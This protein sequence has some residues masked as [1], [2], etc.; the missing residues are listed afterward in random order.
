MTDPVRSFPPGPHSVVPGT[1]V[2]KFRRDVLGFLA[3]L[4]REYGDA[5][6][7]TAGLRRFYVFSHPDAVRDILVTHEDCF[8]K[9]PALRETKDMLG[10]GLLISEGDFHK[11]QRRLA[12]PAFHP[13]R[14]AGYADLMTRFARRLSDRWTD[15]QTIDLHQQMMQL[16]LAVVAKTLFDADVESDVAA[17]GQAMDTSVRMFTR[18]MIPF[19]RLLNLLPLPSNFRF[20][21]ARRL[22]WNK[23]AEFIKQRRDSGIDKG[24]LLSMLLRATDT[25]GD[26][27]GMSDV[28]LRDEC[29]TLFT[30]GHET[31]ANALTFTW[32]LLARH[33][34]IE[35]RMVDEIQTVLGD[36]PPTADDVP[37]LAY[38][39]AVIAESMRLY[40]P[41]WGIGR[42]VS[43]EVEIGGYRLPPK[44]VILVCQWVTH[45]DERFWPEALKFEPQRWLGKSDRPRYAY[46]PFGGGSRACIGEAFAWME[47][48]VLLTTLVQRWRLEL[49]DPAPIDLHPTIT[50]RP[51]NGVAAKLKRR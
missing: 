50:L 35:Q 51:R 21:S 16:T 4:A 7:F 40:P 43:R 14:V 29:I 6:S 39:R 25:E 30:A 48:I 41:A 33:P 9:G 34:E 3:G 36:R 11:R 13:Q 24:D 45:R 5:V 42:E 49:L 15:G 17:L 26:H 8:I 27:T 37:K 28:Q 38:T 44:A 32:Y 12:Q 23:I 31:T 20:W 1:L 22:L 46:F 19:G 47:A 10:Q 2:F 18:A